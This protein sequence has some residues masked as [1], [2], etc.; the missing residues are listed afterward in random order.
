MIVSSSRLILGSLAAKWLAE[1]NLCASA[2]LMVLLLSSVPAS[3]QK[4]NDVAGSEALKLPLVEVSLITD[5]REYELTTEKSIP[6]L[7]RIKNTSED[8]IY[9]SGN[10]IFEIVRVGVERY[11]TKVGDSFTGR[12]PWKDASEPD[13]I[14]LAKDKTLEIHLEVGDLELSDNLSSIDVWKNILHILPVGKFTIH[15]DV[16]INCSNDGKENYRHFVSNEIVI[17]S[18]GY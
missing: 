7:I 13:R 2:L 15:V 6:I 10:P 1:F 18:R 16:A 11:K 5:A 8:T 3:G 12:I 17:S 9:L 4:I 14:Y